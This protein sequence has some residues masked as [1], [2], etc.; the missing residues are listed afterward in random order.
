MNFTAFFYIFNSLMGKWL[1][2]IFT[3]LF[4]AAVWL[5]WWLVFPQALGFKEQNQLFLFTTDFLLERL[6][7]P[8]GF[9]E[10]LSDFITQFNHIIWLGALLNG[11]IFAVIQVLVWQIAG[12]IGKGR[13]D[14][15]YP[16]SF[17]LPTA[18]LCL[19]G[20][21]YVTMGFVM[22]ILLSLV[23]SRIYLSRKST[24][25]AMAAIPVA[26]WLI[27][28]ATCI[29]VFIYMIS[30][31]GKALRRIIAGLALSAAAL[32]LFHYVLAV[33]Y[34]WRQLLL[35]INYYQIPLRQPAS[36][37]IVMTLAVAIPAFVAALPG[38]TR[39][40]T[41]CL[42]AQSA[43]ILFSG[44]SLL[45]K[46]YDRDIYEILAY[47]QLVRNERWEELVSRAEKYQPRSDIGCV[48]VNL[49]LFMTGRMAEMPDFY[50]VG[51]RGL[52]MP[53]VRDCIS[54]IS[55]GEAFWRLGFVNEALR[56]AFDTQESIPDLKKSPRAMM[57]MAECRIV[58]GQYKV[59]SKYIDI[60]KHSLFY[61]K[62]AEEHEKFLYNDEL[63]DADPV[64][65]YLRI[66][67][68]EEDYLFHYPEMDKMLAKLCVQNKNNI[69]AA[70][71]YQA[72]AALMKAENGYKETDTGGAHG[73]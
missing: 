31:K 15:W 57:R 51:T 61:R 44:L 20:D 35:G 67:R 30:G 48:S 27:G 3:L 23:L 63:V 58:N 25:F 29:F 47:D 17:I 7:V 32:V 19:L 2:P 70:W 33:Q 41:V 11:I 38:L 12:K 40:R 37:Y 69:M 66:V 59:A 22:A 28:P 8:G 49:A 34:P 60:L 24:A 10:W 9:A 45:H 46:S 71:Y 56:Y 72:W 62:W 16:L 50:Q 1:K 36:L 52:L 26:F 65:H 64:Y 5:F 54:N 53:R 6:S 43:V 39:C 55:T 21:M 73:S 42:I 13:Y 18:V 4:G 14:V 68:S